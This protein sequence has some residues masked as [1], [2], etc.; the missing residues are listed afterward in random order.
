M[1]N[2]NDFLVYLKMIVIV[3]RQ[4]YIEFDIYNK[5]GDEIF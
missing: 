1:E 5:C 3:G 2:Q 4:S